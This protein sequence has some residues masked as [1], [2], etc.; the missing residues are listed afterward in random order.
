MPKDKERRDIDYY[1]IS[2]KRSERLLA[3]VRPPK[4]IE[5]G[6]G[7]GATLS[8]L[9]ENFRESS[10]VGLDTSITDLRTAN[11]AKL[12]DLVFV[13]A[14]A[15]HQVFSPETFNTAIFKFSLHEIFSRCGNTGINRAI[16]NAYDALVSHGVLIIYD[17][18]RMR[19]QKVRMRIKNDVFKARFKRF[20]EE[21]EP[22]KISFRVRGRW[23]ELDK[24]DCLEFLTK[25]NFHDWDAEKKEAHFY[26]TQ[27]QFRKCLEELGF[28]IRAVRKYR[29]EE[30]IWKDKLKIAN[31]DFDD[32][33]CFVLI[34]AEK[35][36]R[37]D[38]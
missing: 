38:S 27:W 30:E 7:K 9:S 8:L 37:Q 26:Y 19:P 21:F 32:P 3:Y 34:A 23:I 6:C 4:V 14:D 12:E 1:E 33:E 28:S 16:R 22:R 2:R 5:Y 35:V 10:I 17:H 31:V 18:V 29:L 13:K 24:T 11:D 25:G 20:S 15:M 36:D